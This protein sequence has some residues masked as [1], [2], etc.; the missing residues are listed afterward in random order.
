MIRTQISLDPEMYRGAKAVARRKGI[1]LAEFLRRALSAAL[2]EPKRAGRPWMRYAGALASGDPDASRSVNA[3][4]YG[5]P[6]P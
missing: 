6:H 1:S 2:D 5:R 3:V 4:V